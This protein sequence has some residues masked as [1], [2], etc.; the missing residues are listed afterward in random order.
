MAHAWAALFRTQPKG[1]LL[2]ALVVQPT[3]RTAPYVYDKNVKHL[4]PLT[5]THIEIATT[6]L[7]FG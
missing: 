5:C 2:S 3:L 6:R 1:V 4:D 7:T